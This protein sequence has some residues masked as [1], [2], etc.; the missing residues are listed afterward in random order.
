MLF[1][2]WV[3]TGKTIT[4]QKDNEEHNMYLKYELKFM[5][6]FEIKLQRRMKTPL[7]LLI[8]LQ[9]LKLHLKPFILEYS[10]RNLRNIQIHYQIFHLQF[11]GL[12][13]LEHIHNKATYYL[14]C[15]K[16]QQSN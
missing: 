15:M 13:L 6:Y 9:K 4:Q 12:N 3:S 1:I 16:L 8:P 2:L 14:M 5:F 7:K 10:I 11:T